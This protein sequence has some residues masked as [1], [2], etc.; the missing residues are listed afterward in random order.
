[1]PAASD[2]NEAGKRDEASLLKAK[3][4]PLR[5]YTLYLPVQ[6]IQLTYTLVPSPSDPSENKGLFRIVKLDRW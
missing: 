4:A 2:L 3:K 5:T 1:M 6:L